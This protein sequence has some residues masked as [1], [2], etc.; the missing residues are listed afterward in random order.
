MAFRRET[1]DLLADFEKRM[2]FI[3][4]VKSLLEYKYPESI[5]IMIPDRMILDNL[6]LAVL[7]FIMDRTLSDEKKCTM[8]DIARFIQ[9]ITEI[10][11]ESRVDAELLAK[12]IVIEI[13]QNGGV[14]AEY[15][16][17]YSRSESFANMTIR[18]LNEEKGSYH[19]TD[20][21]FDFLYRSKEI[22]SEL[23][24]SVTRFRMTEYMKRNNYAKALDQSRELVNRIRNMKTSMDDFLFRCRESLAKITVDEYEAI[25]LRVRSLL[26]N[27]Y[28]ELELIQKNARE[29]SAKL[30][31]AI[32][33]GVNVEETQKHKFQLD[34]ILRN[35]ALTVSEQRV[36]INK[37][38]SLADSYSQLLDESYVMLN[39]KRF[40][41]QEELM[42]PLRHLGD[43]LGDAAKYLL[44]PLTKPL[45]NDYFSIENFYAPQ[46]K[47]KEAEAEEG[48]DLSE[49]ENH[50]EIRQEARNLR[51]SLICR[52]FFHYAS[53]KTRFTV[54]EYIASLSIL[55]IMNFCSE[56]ALPQVLLS[57]YAM[58]ELDIA[59][60]EAA[61]E[62]VVEP[63]GEFE[64]AWCLARTPAEDHRMKKIVFSKLEQECSFLVQRGEETRNITL[65]D[66][67]IEV[68]K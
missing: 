35:I 41:M 31:E 17:F 55:E 45:F 68:I 27:E 32:E 25:I 1:A 63:L 20:D 3:N 13:L 50:E 28:L 21:A 65:T 24:Y 26:D 12:H 14:L 60:W 51:F 36:L 9:E 48:F 5:R 52:H 61:N 18:L 11:P 46:R 10:L 39:Y 15:R 37:K 7:V 8:S 62:I 30:A 53:D 29:Q 57:M 4:I 23:D 44:F 43:A 49:G 67:E 33:T 40:N 64:L 6:V 66:F 47:L 42:E 34:E 59:G 16:T 19:L 56:N 38:S 54:S 2:K 58:Q 22:E